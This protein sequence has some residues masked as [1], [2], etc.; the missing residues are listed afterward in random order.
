MFRS[1]RRVSDFAIRGLETRW[2]HIPEAERGAVAAH[3]YKKES[4][5]WKNMTLDEKRAGICQYDS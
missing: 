4:G 5:D 2:S 1:V 3:V